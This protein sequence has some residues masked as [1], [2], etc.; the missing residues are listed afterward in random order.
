MQLAEDLT[1]ITTEQLK[2]MAKNCNKSEVYLHWTAGHY[3]HVYKDYHLS[4]DYDGQIYAPCNET[5]LNIY[6]SHT[7]LRNSNSIGVAICGCYKA[8]ANH[9]KDADLGNE[10]VTQNQIETLAIICAIL[11]KYGKIPLEDML[12]HCEIALRDGYGP[13][14][15]DPDLRWDLWFLRDN[16][17]GQM[18]NGGDVIRG[19]A[20]WYLQ[21]YNI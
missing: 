9:G 20:R 4:V 17:D 12:T 8:V 2:E 19:K 14:Q 13:Y 5:D 11:C 21:N 1:P 18:K 6:R 7:W 10:P 3:G 15:G 16:S